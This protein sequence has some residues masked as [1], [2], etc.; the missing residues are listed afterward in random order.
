MPGS[1]KAK[2]QASRDGVLGVADRIWRSSYAGDYIGLAI[3]IVLYSL[4]RTFSEPFYTS[5]RLDDTRI[6]W[7]HAEVEHVPV[8]ML[9]IYAAGIPLILLV[10]WAMIFRPGHHKAHAVLLGLVTSVLMTTFLTDIAKDAVGRPRPDLISRCKPEKSTPMHELVPI[11]VCTETRRHLLHDGFRSWPSGHSSFAFA[12]L[13]WLALALTSQT[14]ALRPRANL[15][16]VLVCLAPLLAAALIA[17]SRLEDY[18]HDVGDVVTG[19]SLG[20]AVTYFNW[21]R[22]FPSLLSAE[23][24]QPYLQSPGGD[25]SSPSAFQRV[26]DEEEGY[27]SDD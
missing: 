23:C 18:R 2:A 21:R 26:R 10:A 17:A 7:P 22:Y 19:S 12:G 6:Q 13:G 25:G 27:G 20:F 8:A 16:Y 9:F 4:F 5:F 3:L 11:D 15:V 1:V 24:D 14:R